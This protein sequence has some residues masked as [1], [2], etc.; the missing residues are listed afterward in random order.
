MDWNKA[1]SRVAY[2]KS[3]CHNDAAGFVYLPYVESLSKRYQ[4]GERTED[5]Y[6]SMILLE[7]ANADIIR[8]TCGVF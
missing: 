7:D 4:N 8:N 1:V 3:M 5:L 2:I 6:M